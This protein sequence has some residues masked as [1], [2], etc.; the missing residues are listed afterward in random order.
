MTKRRKRRGSHG[1]YFADEVDGDWEDLGADRYL[2]I[3][4]TTSYSVPHHR[5]NLHRSASWGAGA[6]AGFGGAYMGPYSQGDLWDERNLAR[7]PRDW[8]A[9]FTREGV[10]G[11]LK[12]LLPTMLLPSSDIHGAFVILVHL[13]R[14]FTSLIISRTTRLERL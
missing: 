2:G 13:T 12:G 7:R 8:R 5:V 11:E 6:G 3:K 4:R 1:G 10:A 14:F 9:D